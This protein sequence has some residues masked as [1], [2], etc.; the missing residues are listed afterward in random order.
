[1]QVEI[2]LVL[3]VACSLEDLSVQISIWDKDNP[4]SS[5]ITKSSRAYQG[6]FVFGGGLAMGSAMHQLSKLLWEKVLDAERKL[7]TA[8]SRG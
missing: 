8:P 4:T 2:T 3:D 6:D 1:M 5:K 7:K